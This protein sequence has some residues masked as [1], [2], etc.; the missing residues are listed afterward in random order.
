MEETGSYNSVREMG[1]GGDA[2]CL[3]YA[4]GPLNS[5]GSCFFKIIR[6]QK[7]LV[8]LPSNCSAMAPGSL[9]ANV[10]SEWGEREVS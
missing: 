2:V 10:D 9:H 1:Q 6:W 5:V 3:E 8:I 4:S 7:T